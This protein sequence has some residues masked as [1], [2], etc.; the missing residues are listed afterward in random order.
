MLLHLSGVSPPLSYATLA[1]TYRRV[2][3]QPTVDV[4]PTRL[5]I[6][7]QPFKQPPAFTRRILY[8]LEPTYSD[9]A[10][11][12]AVLLRNLTPPYISNEAEV[13]HRRLTRRNDLK[14]TGI[15]DGGHPCRAAVWEGQHFLILSTDGLSDLY[16]YLGVS[17]EM[18]PQASVDAVVSVLRAPKMSGDE[19][20]LTDGALPVPNLAKSVL[21]AAL[22]GED[23]EGVS[24]MITAQ[25]DESWVDDTTVVVQLL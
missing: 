4:L 12:E 23:T 13:V 22:G 20:D 5:A 3:H 19:N 11:W 7:D 21:L 24:R 16:D 1:T 17:L 14:V 9:I 8:N 6:G 15:S 25:L 10:P 2:K 18:L